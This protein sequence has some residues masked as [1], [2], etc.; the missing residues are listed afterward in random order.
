MSKPQ[1]L[2]REMLYDDV[3]PL[4]EAGKLMHSEGVFSK[5]DYNVKKVVRMLDNYL[6]DD[7]LALVA[8][9]DDGVNDEI[10]IV[11]WFLAH[12]GAHYFGMSKLAIEHCMYIHPLHRGGSTASRF[13]KKFDHWAR[14]NEAEVM[15]FMPCN[16]GPD[17]RWEK[18]AKKNGYAHTGYIFQKDL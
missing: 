14:Y 8:D 6:E 9:Y 3:E 12:L 5:A 4:A 1:I 16:N 10:N 18:F 7:K 15:L 17:N 13:M 2:I 11:G